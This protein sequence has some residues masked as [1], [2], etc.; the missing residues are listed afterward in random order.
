MHKQLRHRKLGDLL[1]AQSSHSYPFDWR[2]KN[3]NHLACSSQ[4]FARIVNSSRWTK[5]KKEIVNGESAFTQGYQTVVTKTRQRA[6][7]CSSNL[8]YAEDGT[9]RH[10]G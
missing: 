10:D 9:I 5:L 3:F 4:W 1:L 2:T 8:S 6:L 7:V